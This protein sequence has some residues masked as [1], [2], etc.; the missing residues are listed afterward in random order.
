MTTGRK[1]LSLTFAA[2]LDTKTNEKVLPNGV[3]SDLENAVFERVGQLRKRQ[4]FETQ[5]REIVGSSEDLSAGADVHVYGEYDEKILVTDGTNGYLRTADDCFKPVGQLQDVLLSAEWQHVKTDVLQGAPKMMVFQNYAFE[6]WYEYDSEQQSIAFSNYQPDFGGNDKVDVAAEEEIDIGSFLMV[7]GADGELRHLRVVESVLAI[8]TRTLTLDT[9]GQSLLYPVGASGTLY[10]NHYDIFVQ[11]HDIDRDVYIVPRT[12]IGSYFAPCYDYIL[13]NTDDFSVYDSRARLGGCYGFPPIQWVT[14]NADRAYLLVSSRFEATPLGGIPPLFQINRLIDYWSFDTTLDCQMVLPSRQQL[15]TPSVNLSG[16]ATC[17]VA[18]TVLNADDTVRTL[19]LLLMTDNGLQYEGF[20][21][22][23]AGGIQQKSPVE[24]FVLHPRPFMPVA[25]PW[26]TQLSL[27]P[28]YDAFGHYVTPYVSMRSLANVSP[29]GS[30]AMQYTAYDVVT[31]TGNVTTS[32]QFLTTA[33]MVAP[34]GGFPSIKRGDQVR[35]TSAAY[36]GDLFVYE[37]LSDAG[38]VVFATPFPFLTITGAI[39]IQ[40]KTPTIR[41]VAV[42]YPISGG[43]TVGAE[44]ILDTTGVLINGSFRVSLPGSANIEAYATISEYDNDLVLS[45]GIVG[46]INEDTPFSRY[47]HSH[48]IV[49]YQFNVLTGSLVKLFL[50]HRGASMLSDVFEH[51]GRYYYVMGLASKQ[52]TR[53]VFET[54]ASVVGKQLYWQSSCVLLCRDDGNVLAKGVTGRSAVCYSTDQDAKKAMVFGRHNQEPRQRLFA[55]VSRVTSTPM[56][57]AQSDDYFTGVALQSGLLSATR[58]VANSVTDRVYHSLADLRLSFQDPQYRCMPSTDING[59]FYAGSGLLWGEDQN[60]LHEVGFISSPE[61]ENVEVIGSYDPLGIVT[62]Y[63]PGSSTFVHNVGANPTDFPLGR[64]LTFS[65]FEDGEIKLTGS[66]TIVNYDSGT[67]TVTALGDISLLVVGFQ[68]G[69]YIW[70]GEQSKGAEDGG[71]FEGNQSYLYLLHYTYIN[72]RGVR[73]VSPLSAVALAQTGVTTPAQAIELTILTSSATY[74]DGRHQL[75][76]MRISVYRTSAGNNDFQYVGSLPYDVTTDRQVFRDTVSD[77][78]KADNEFIYAATASEQSVMPPSITSLTQ[79]RS[80]LVVGTS[81]R[82]VLYSSRLDKATDSLLPATNQAPRFNPLANIQVNAAASTILGLDK[83]TDHLLIFTSQGVFFVSGDGPNAQLT[84]GFYPSARLFAPEE[85]ILEGSSTLHTPVGVF[86]Q[87]ARGLQL[88]NNGLQVAYAG[89]PIEAFLQDAPIAKKMI[90]RDAR[91]EAL[92]VFSDGQLF[93]FNYH[94]NQWSRATFDTGMGEHACLGIVNTGVS[95]GL[96]RLTTDGRFQREWS[97]IY[98]QGSFPP[99][100]DTRY[101]YPMRIVTGWMRFG[102]LQEVYRVRRAVL[103][104]TPIS[105]HTL[106]VSVAVDFNDSPVEDF[107]IF[108][109][110]Q[111]NTRMHLRSQ[112]SRAHK[113]TIEDV[114]IDYIVGEAYRIEG[115]AFDVVKEEETFKTDIS[116]DMGG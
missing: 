45:D 83:T 7:Y 24:R 56:F 16:T 13:N 84:Q 65:L 31:V 71:V 54:G 75:S 101:Q 32:N 49:R 15:S 81:E 43:P 77:D 34:V 76:P 96:L 113:F 8:S 9:A 93:V 14:D 41:G 112:K 78:D 85:G 63:T 35:I 19:A 25:G 44:G 115:I 90:C 66:V 104:L 37:S 79:Y 33:L 51:E 17:L 55:D 109:D 102:E 2:G 20:E 69:L 67:R 116:G 97:N 72:N 74:K 3:L 107:E 4:G 61:V 87:T 38:E 108:I 12:Q 103:M 114:S 62:G 86:Y 47:I 52:F 82:E 10:T 92:F 46:A 39:S 111:S 94:F 18:D 70:F 50:M 58:N 99:R 42:N 91:K 30:V 27:D 106:K 57:D 88:I 95:Q 110:G 68:A 40:V 36:T 60:V 23:G 105:P 29:G 59:E 53:N 28:T 11:V 5:K 22:T 64:E 26:V 1:M 98:D 73:Q 89:A 6:A 100:T 80:R 21:F 48:R